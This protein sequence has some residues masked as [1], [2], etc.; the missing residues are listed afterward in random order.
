M[1]EH[2]LESPIESP[3]DDVAEQGVLVTPDDEGGE[4]DHGDDSLEVDPA[5]RADQERSVGLGD[6]EYR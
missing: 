1:S 3:E 5:D 2:R 6:D 4:R